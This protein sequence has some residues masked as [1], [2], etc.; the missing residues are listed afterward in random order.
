MRICQLNIKQSSN[1]SDRHHDALRRIAALGFDH[2]L[3]SGWPAV[4]PGDRDTLPALTAVCADCARHGLTPLI[5]VSLDRY[6]AD[7]APIDPAWIDHGAPAFAPHDTD[8]HLPGVR[9]RW[10]SPRIA[11]GLVD[12]WATQLRGALAAGVTGFCLRAPA[13][14]PGRHWASLTATLRGDPAAGE[15]AQPTRP[16][17]LA[18]TPGLRRHSSKTSCRD[19]STAPSALCRGGTI[20]AHG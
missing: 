2:V 16:L 9:L 1:P 20:A 14:V 13:R 3:L 7:G 6:R 8:N 17:F 4:I 10:H 5:D 15:G 19:S 18:W 11:A 12:W